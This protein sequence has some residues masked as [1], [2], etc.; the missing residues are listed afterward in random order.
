MLI[1]FVM[2]ISCFSVIQTEDL[3]VPAMCVVHVLN[4][5][6]VF[7]LE[8]LQKDSKMEISPGENYGQCEYVGKSRRAVHSRPH[9]KSTRV[10]TGSDLHG[11]LVVNVQLS[12]IKYLNML[13]FCSFR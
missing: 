5:R 13:S 8:V 10:V 3:E 1:F 6:R 4:P 9:T 11:W 7:S 2:D 12:S